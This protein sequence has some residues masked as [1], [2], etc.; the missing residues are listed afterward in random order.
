MLSGIHTTKPRTQRYIDAFVKGSG[1]GRIYHFRQ[2][3]ELPKEDLT[4]YGILAG[5]G[6]VY[7][8]CE[9]ENKNFYFMDHGYFT[10]A[11]VTPHWL[12]ITKNKHCQNILHTRPVDRYEKN[13]KEDIK[14]WKKGKKILVL[15]PTNAIAN[16]FNVTDWLEETIKTLKENTDREIDIRE[17]PYNPI[18]G[19][20]HVGATVKIETKTVHRGEINWNDY[21]AMVTYNSNTMVASLTNGVPV[22]CDPVNS[23]AAPISETDF[24]KIETPVY[25]DRIALFSSLA[26][27]NWTLDEMADGTAW[28][29][30]NES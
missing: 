9:K 20:D 2:L 26:Y 25:G 19:K 12:R 13:F 24:T 27:N 3:K 7:K 10:N 21:H 15:P 1:Q 18:V 22:F 5:S 8:D 28:R 30:L 11:H 14:P 4:M 17:K 6:E 29:M 23:A 16:F